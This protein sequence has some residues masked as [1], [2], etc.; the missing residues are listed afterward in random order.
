MRRPRAENAEGEEGKKEE[1]EKPD[2]AE[3]KP[4]EIRERRHEKRQQQAFD[5]LAAAKVTTGPVEDE[6][7]FT[8]VPKD[9]RAKPIRQAA[10][11]SNWNDQNKQAKKGPQNRFA[12]GD[13]D[14]W[15][16]E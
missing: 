6:D 12:A 8:T 1:G 3:E 11:V 4:Q 7:G 9:N 10:P 14:D 13:A 16:R 5:P 2:Q 15:S